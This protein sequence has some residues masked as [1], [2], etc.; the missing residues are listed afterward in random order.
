RLVLL[1][2]ASLSPVAGP[3]DL[4]GSFQTNPL[5]AAYSGGKFFVARSTRGT[6]DVSAVDATTLKELRVA[7]ISVGGDALLAARLIPVG[8]GVLL[9][10]SRGATRLSFGWAPAAFDAAGDEVFPLTDVD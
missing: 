3:V 4:P 5:A 6:L 2:P 7:N 8:N 10:F 1:D 9:M